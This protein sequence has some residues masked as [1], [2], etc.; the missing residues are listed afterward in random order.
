MDK[1]S[2]VSATPKSSNEQ[3]QGAVNSDWPAFMEVQD[4]I[5]DESYGSMKISRKV[6][7]FRPS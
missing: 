7:L 4:F 3:Q 6:Q 1:P 5:A 2:T